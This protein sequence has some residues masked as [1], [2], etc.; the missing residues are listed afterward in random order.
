MGKRDDNSIFL[1]WLD[2]SWKNSATTCKLVIYSISSQAALTCIQ[3]N[4]IILAYF[5]WAFTN[6]NNK[7]DAA[8]VWQP[9]WHRSGS[10]NCHLQRGRGETSQQQTGL[11]QVPSLTT[12]YLAGP[13]TP[14]LSCTITELSLLYE[15][16]TQHAVLEICHLL[17]IDFNAWLWYIHNAFGFT[18]AGFNILLN[19]IHIFFRIKSI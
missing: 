19:Y 9:S 10:I 1:I 6:R 14:Q 7:Q 3:W 12:N 16:Q 4:P 2:Y 18:F 15:R 8:D 5:R 11:C 13:A 17:Q